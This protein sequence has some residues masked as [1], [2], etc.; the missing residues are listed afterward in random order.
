M[1][2]LNLFLKTEEINPIY[3]KLPSLK[4]A[5][6]LVLIALFLQIYLEVDTNSNKQI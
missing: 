3:Q 5:N 6:N 2:Q 4:S 1:S